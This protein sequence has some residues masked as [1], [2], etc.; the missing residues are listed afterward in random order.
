MQSVRDVVDRQLRWQLCEQ[1][2]RQ[3][4]WQV[5]EQLDWQLHWQ[6][7]RQLHDQTTLPIKNEILNTERKGKRT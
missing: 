2:H 1:L 6:L 5:R 3:L 7:Y 4:H